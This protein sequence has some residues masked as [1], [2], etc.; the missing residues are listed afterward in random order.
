MIILVNDVAV[1][2]GQIGDE[3]RIGN[4]SATT[5]IP[6]CEEDRQAITQFVS[7]NAPITED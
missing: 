5:I 2:N 3:F 4:T 7:Q 6:Q 1:V